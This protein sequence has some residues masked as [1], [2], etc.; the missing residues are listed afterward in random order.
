MNSIQSVRE[1][2]RL[3]AYTAAAMYGGGVVI[4]GI[5]SLIP[6]GPAVSLTPGAAA[7]GAVVLLLTVGPRLPRWGLAPLGPVGALLIAYSQVTTP[8][9]G[10]GAVLYMWPVLWTAF[11]FGR[12][13]AVAIVACIGVAHGLAVLSL[14]ADSRFLARWIEVMFSVSIVAAVV[15]VL[16]ANNDKL[17]ARLVGE[18]RTD[19]LTGLLNRHGFEEPAA[20]ELAHAR[21]EHRSIAAITIDIDYFKR[22]NDE[23][24]HE[25]G[26]RVLARLGA[27]LTAHCR[28]IDVVARV[29]GEEFVVLLPSSD[30]AD[31]QEY[32]QR[33]RRALA[34]RDLPG[35][36][37]VR[38]SAG[39]AA[40]V[41]PANVEELLERADSA[42]YAAKRGGRDRVVVAEQEALEPALALG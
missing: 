17:L 6:G 30:S 35:L 37:A 20:I 12:R 15:Q 24:G 41:A 2:K 36:P 16:V 19:K 22:V 25:T 13:G 7:L 10:D 8:G 39:I 3:I 18:A 38:V 40:T 4:N 5:E 1:N 11:F 33:V 28:E 9:P 31:A 42:L 21:R 27:V 23:W 26:D 29:G 34:V 14:P 32:M